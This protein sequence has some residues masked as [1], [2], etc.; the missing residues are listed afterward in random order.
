MKKCDC[1]RCQGHYTEGAELIDSVLDVVRKEAEG[2]DC[3]LAARSLSLCFQFFTRPD[4][5]W[6][7]YVDLLEQHF[8][9]GKV[10]ESLPK[11]SRKCFKSRPGLQGFQLCHSLGGVTGAGMGT[12]L[13]SKVREEYPDRISLAV[14]FAY[15]LSILFCSLRQIQLPDIP[16]RHL[17]SKTWGIMETFSVI[18]SP[19]VSDTVVEPYN[20]SRFAWDSVWFVIVRDDVSVVGRPLWFLNPLSS[21]EAVLSFHQLVEN[22]DESFLVGQWS[23]IRY[24]L[25]HFEADYPNLWWP[26]PFGVCCYEWCHLLLAFP[27]PAELR[28]AQDCCEP[29]PF[30][31]FA[32]LHDWLC[33]IDLS[34][35]SAVSCTDGARVDP[36][37][38]GCNLSSSLFFF[39][40][41]FLRAVWKTTS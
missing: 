23:I 6:Y 27:W 25:P 18:P 40:L 15:V 12:L 8:S 20:A 26:E 28:L 22:S 10:P 17:S 36:A 1:A 16:C 29:G 2:C 19:K 14:R 13:I 41:F 34:W 38:T 4:T 32:L 37:E 21:T 3:Y 5:Q 24:L 33:T 11:T 35:L 9:V 30:P 7:L 31:T 39:I